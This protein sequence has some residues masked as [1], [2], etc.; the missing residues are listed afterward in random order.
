MIIEAIPKINIDSLTSLQ[1]TRKSLVVTQEAPWKI[2]YNDIDL[3]NL[4][5]LFVE[6]MVNEDYLENVS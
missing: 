4:K 6:D 3:K 5:L 2:V 1:E